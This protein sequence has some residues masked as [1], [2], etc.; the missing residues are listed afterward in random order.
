M[1]NE[2]RISWVQAI[3]TFAG[4]L[5]YAGIILSRADG[6]PLSGVAY[7][8][9]LLWIIVATIIATILGAIASAIF[10]AIVHKDLD[11]KSDERDRQINTRGEYFGLFA[12]AAGAGGGM[13]LAMVQAPHFWIANAIFLGFTVSSLVSAVVKIISYRRGF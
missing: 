12:L 2:E 9:P 4:Y 11:P 3:I 6:G 7:A 10:G 1:T 8:G 5:I 13:V